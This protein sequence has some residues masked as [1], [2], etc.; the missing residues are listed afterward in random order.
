[1]PKRQPNQ[2]PTPAA[3]LAV[4]PVAVVSPEPVTAPKIESTPAVKPKR[5][6]HRLWLI[7]P[8]LLA[9]V[10]ALAYYM[11]Q[12]R[13]S[14]G[15]ATGSL[16]EHIGEIVDYSNTPLAGEDNDRINVLLLGIGGAGHDGGTLTDTI[17]VANIKPSTKQVALLSLPRDLIVKIYNSDQPNDW[18]GHKI[19]YAY[20]LGGIDL[21]REKVSAVTGLKMHYYIVLDFAGFRQVIDDVAGVD[22]MVEHNFVGLYG[23]KDLSTPCLQKNLYQLS[24]GAYCAVTFKSGLQHFDGER[25]LI[26]ARIRK[27]APHSPNSAEGSDFARAQRQQQILE[28]FKSKL[29]SANTIIRPSRMTN[30]LR[31]I[32]EHLETNLKLSEMGRLLSIVGDIDSDRIIHQVV[33][34]SPGSLVMT[35]IYEPTGASV[36]VPVAGN[37]DYSAIQKLAKHIFQIKAG[38]NQSDSAANPTA[39]TIQ[40]LNGTATAGLATTAAANLAAQGFTITDVSNTPTKDYLTTR[41]YNFTNGDATA[42]LQLVQ[43]VVG[44]E[45]AS[46]E[47]HDTLLSLDPAGTTFDSSADFIIIL[48]ADVA[49]KSN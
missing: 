30:V 18:L 17:M 49:T 35:K 37:Y 16:L 2:N 26:Y 22:V 8:L 48:G 40:V 43:Q 36:V 32:D 5:F 10:A 4:Q 12:V 25:A 42:T 7:P 3:A 34:D 33:D 23:T 15:S 9:V 1:M 20:A 14:R 41:I 28:A 46:A 45:V 21:A 38:T 29:L 19:N 47:E 39:A 44:G 31:D 27:L 13:G 24:D 6:N 11:Y